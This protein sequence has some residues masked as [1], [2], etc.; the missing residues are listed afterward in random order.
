MKKKSVISV[1]HVSKYFSGNTN[2]TL[3]K[4]IHFQF[5]KKVTSIK[6]LEDISF[7]IQS[8]EIVGLYGP[9]GSG[10]STLFRILGGILKPT[11][12]SVTID[13]RV[14]AVLELGAGLHPELTGLDNISLYSSL[15]GTSQKHLGD[16]FQKIIQF[17]G[18]EKFLHLPVKKYS[19]GMIARLAFSIAIFAEADILLFDEILSVGDISFQEKCLQL[20]K[21]MRRSK[22]ILISSHDLGLLYQICDRVLFLEQGK[23]L[24]QEESNIIDFLRTMPL[25]G[26]FSLKAQ[27]NSMFP[28]IKVGSEIKVVKT[29][30]SELVPGD[31]IAF[32]MENMPRIIVHRII[33]VASV[34][35]GTICITKGDN[36][37]NFDSWEVSES[38][39]I[40]QVKII[41]KRN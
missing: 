26:Q 14:A 8:H 39:F 12:G 17:A 40:G 41:S 16:Q 15:L 22:T 7:E 21:T 10:K 13:G 29:L 38:E 35:G 37:T 1:D 25:G 24:N 19:S 27:S 9:N 11:A 28:L 18:V 23:L 20:I 6:V 3:L 2:Q 34:G 31:I 5:K 32:A 33:Q 36:A 30:F 4:K